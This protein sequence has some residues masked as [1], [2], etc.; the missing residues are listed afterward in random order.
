MN[1]CYIVGAGDF[2]LKG[3]APDAS[4]LVI[5]ADGGYRYLKNAFIAPS[6]VAG[7]FDSM[8]DVSVPENIE[9]FRFPKEKDDT[10][11][12][13]AVREGIQR[14]YKVFRLY[15]G[16]GS[17]PD[18]FY[19]NLQLLCGYAKQGYDIA[20]ICPLFNVYAVSNGALT[21]SRPINTVL[22]VFSLD[23]VSFGVTLEGVKYTLKNARLSSA[24][25]LGVSNE[26]TS[27][28]ARISVQ[29]GTLLVFAYDRPEAP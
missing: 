8:G 10:D 28:T 2:T 17:R 27:D 24:F 14:G 13:L 6:L 3:L 11:M 16:S 26:F 23:E 5:A 29:S 19:A 9:I 7:D 15:G 4:D 1:T 22:S 18:H 25:P 21:L 12:G 20:L